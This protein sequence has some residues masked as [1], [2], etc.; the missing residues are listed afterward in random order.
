[1]ATSFMQQAGVMSE[2]IARQALMREKPQSI[3]I[4][5]AER[6]I[7]YPDYKGIE[8][9]PVGGVDRVWLP[10]LEQAI[11][12]GELPPNSHVPTVMIGLATIFYG[13][14]L[15]LRQ[16]NLAAISNMYRQQLRVFWSGVRS[17]T[18]GSS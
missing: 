8:E 15:V 6:Q 13:L 1:M 4:G 17:A 9:V 18:Q 12:S 10:A 16:G 7:A 11:Q 14:P 3:D 2:I 5:P